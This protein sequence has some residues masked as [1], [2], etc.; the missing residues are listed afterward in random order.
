LAEAMGEIAYGASFIEWFAEEA[1][2][3]YGDI[4]PNTIAD[5]RLLVIKQPVGVVCTIT[6]WNFPTAMITRKAAPA[7]AAGCPIIIK[8]AAETPLSAL[9]LAELADRAGFPPG[10]L[11]VITTDKAVEVGGEMTSNPDVRKV[12]FTGST[13]VGKLLMK[14]CADTVKKISLELGGNAPFIVFDDADIDAAVEGAMASKYRN[15]GQTCVCANRLIVQESVYDEFAQKLATAVEDLNVGESTEQNVTQGP[16]INEAAVQ[17][18][19]HHIDDAVSKGASIATGG[20]RHQ[21]GGTF[22]EPTVLINV[23]NSM[24]VATEETF[25]PVAPIFKFNT[26]QQ[27]L[28]LANDTEFGLA[29]YFYARDIGRI[30]RIAEGLDTGIVGINEGIISTEVAPFGGVK[31]SGLGREG[32]KYGIEEFL[33][34]KYLCMGMGK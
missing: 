3:V 21:K 18:V 14:Q 19:E 25:G 26:E 29:A 7:L 24:L 27:A 1:K 22:F 6:P 5:R 32:S 23:D 28:D 20:N 12:S 34:M 30:W 33:E 11:N 31:E 8:P 15:S 17:K 10:I 13:A 2:R 4:I 9:A 16:L